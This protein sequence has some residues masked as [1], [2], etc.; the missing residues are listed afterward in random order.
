MALTLDDLYASPD[1]YL[2]SFDGDAAVFLPMDRFAY[3]RSIFLDGRISA[4]SNG[5][6]RLPTATLT[7]CIPRSR[8][9]CWIFH[10]AH[11]GS[12]LL[13]R[14]LDDPS[15]NLV[16]REPLALRQLAFAQRDERLALAIAMLSKRYQADAPTIVKANVPV[17]FLLPDLVALE[18][19][20]HAIFLHYS[21]RDYV[22][23]ILRNDNHRKWLHNITAQLAPHIGDVSKLADPERVA[24]L[25]LAQMRAFAEAILQMPNA[26]SLDAETFF[27]EPRSVLAAAAR[28][29]S[30]PMPNA[31]IEERVSGPLFATYSK[32]P[33]LAFD[34][35]ARLER[36]DALEVLL[37]SDVARA[38]GWIDQVSTDPDP[39]ATASV[40]ASVSLV[41]KSST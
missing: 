19:G 36:R 25:W 41:A 21:L 3:H 12:T 20:A 37:A 22:L 31:L 13:A 16:L 24:A 8:P 4:A 26:R 38:Q 2:H 7:G 11:C 28:H 6:M 1:H 10:I 35:A 27:A 17:N 18:P 34:N 40:I 14:A 23:A 29:S 32:N 5:M 9:M 30:V 33:A 15:C 39:D